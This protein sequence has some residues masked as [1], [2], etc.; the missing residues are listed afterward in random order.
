MY[1]K[2]FKVLMVRKMADPDGTTPRKIAKKIGVSSSTL[3]RWANR[4]DIVDV[5]GTLPFSVRLR[6]SVAQK[7]FYCR[8]KDHQY[9]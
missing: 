1:A 9:Q 5:C 3:Y 8:Q 2:A 4:I 6:C 7:D